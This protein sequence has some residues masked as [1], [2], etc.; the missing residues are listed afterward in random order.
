MPG[1]GDVINGIDGYY[2]GDTYEIHRLCQRKL[3]VLI[4]NGRHEESRTRIYV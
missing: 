2:K 3:Y 4:H 1:V